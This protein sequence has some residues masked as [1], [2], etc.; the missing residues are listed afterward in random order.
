MCLNTPA[1]KAL[2]DFKVIMIFFTYNE[3]GDT[4]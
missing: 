1:D 3:F 2:H 4:L